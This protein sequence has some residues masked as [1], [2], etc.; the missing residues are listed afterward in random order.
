MGKKGFLRLSEVELNQVCREGSRWAL[1]S[2]YANEVDVRRTEE[3]GCLEGANPN[4][5]S[6]R[7]KERGR[8]QVGTLGAGNHFIEVDIVDTSSWS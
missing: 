6:K 4:T 8:P 2:G 3:G 5:V 7:A 1:K